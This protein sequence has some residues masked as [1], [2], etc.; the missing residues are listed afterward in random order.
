M[1]T[2]ENKV[3]E[4]EFNLKEAIANIEKNQEKLIEEKKVKGW[5][6]PWSGKLSK[7]KV[8]KNY[9]TFCLIKD[10]KDVSFITA[11]I[12]DGTAMIDGFPRVTTADYCLLHKGRPFFILP[13]WSMK[14]FSPVE[15]YAETE[16]EKMN[17]SGRRLVLTKLRVEQIKPK[18]GF[19]GGLGWIILIL[20]IAGIGYYFM[21]G[22]KL[23]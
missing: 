6:L 20:A 21:K 9:A 22:G 10:N 8:K 3:P 11:P 5:K 2:E 17:M 19:G 12:E 23:F 1:E 7:G 14:P 15:N 18:K 4:K 13:Y 16:K